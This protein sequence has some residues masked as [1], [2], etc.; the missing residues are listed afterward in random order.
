MPTASRFRTDLMAIA[1]LAA[2]LGA[3][4]AEAAVQTVDRPIPDRYIVV[5]KADAGVQSVGA[6]QTTAQVASELASFYGGQRVRTFE[7]ALTGFAFRGSSA[8]AEN[9]SRDRR[10]EYVAQDGL[11]T[12]SSVQNPVPSW[13]LD[14][15]DQ[16]ATELDTTYEYASEGSDVDLYVV[17]TGVRSTHVDFGGRVDTENAFT[18]IE[19]GRGTEDCLGHGTMVAGIAG[20]S[21]FG[22][23]KGVSIHPVRVIGCDG[24][25]S[26]SNTIA[27]LD[28]IT[29]RQESPAAR[30]AVVNLSIRSDFSFPLEAAVDAAL[31]AGVVVV[32]AAGNDGMETP[33]YVSPQRMPGVLTV[34]A[35]DE[36]G[37]RWSQSS[38][39]ECVDLFAPGAQVWSTFIRNDEDSL[40]SSGTSFAAPHV[41]G[42]AALLLAA[43]PEATPAEIHAMIVDGA[44]EGVLSDID[45]AGTPPVPE[46]IFG[47]GFESGDIGGWLPPD[48]LVGG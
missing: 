3:S 4:G 1:V 14:R 32:S 24:E 9:L 30:R 37:A 5:L 22:V 8:A 48:T 15:I 19:D 42:A 23:A 18:A 13:G 25:G 39:G 17:D 36:S 2:T 6:T 10:V 38:F 40:P 20:G 41:A 11:V 46:S 47:D 21:T 45:V 7:K 44:T 31:A 28:W 12:L 33:C 43:H 27:G 26:I 34:A 35:S 16:R 29:A